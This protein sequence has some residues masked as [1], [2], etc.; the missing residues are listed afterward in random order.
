MFQLKN[1]F[2]SHINKSQ[3]NGCFFLYLITASR[4]NNII[5]VNELI[6][7]VRFRFYKKKSTTL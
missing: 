4:L 2:L 1:V 5:I 3:V 6:K 7:Q